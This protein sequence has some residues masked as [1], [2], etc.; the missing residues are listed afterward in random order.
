MA[1]AEL[2]QRA[3]AIEALQRFLQHAG[4][5]TPAATV[6]QANDTVARLQDTL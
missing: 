5:D 1:H 2:G 4:P 3:Q 6:K